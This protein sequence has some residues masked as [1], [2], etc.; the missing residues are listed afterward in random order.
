[1]SPIHFY[2]VLLRLTCCLVV[3]Q[4]VHERSME[5]PRFICQSRGGRSTAASPGQYLFRP[6]AQQFSHLRPD[7]WRYRSESSACRSGQGPERFLAACL[8]SPSGW[9]LYLLQLVGHMH[10]QVRKRREERF[11]GFAPAFSCELTSKGVVDET[12]SDQFEGCIQVFVVGALL[13]TPNYGL[14]RFS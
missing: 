5:R 7:Q 11:V 2:S 14:I 6:N 1:M 8:S 4:S 9:L 3:Q 13:E 10:R 12:G